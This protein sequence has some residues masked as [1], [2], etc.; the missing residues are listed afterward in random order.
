MYNKTKFFR[1]DFPVFR[2][3]ILDIED[4]V[5]AGNKNAC[6]PYYLTR[7]LKQ[8]ADIIFMPYNYLLDPK[9]RKNQGID[10]GNNV[11]LLDEAHNIEKTCEE[12]ASLEV[13]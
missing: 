12:A 13:G 11:I 4:L 7:E 2:E 5:K 3:N 10:L 9:T 6:C 8:S 1:K